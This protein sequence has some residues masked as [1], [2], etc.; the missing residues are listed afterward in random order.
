MV[1][2]IQ[3][4]HQDN[5]DL[6]SLAGELPSELSRLPDEIIDNFESVLV[7]LEKQQGNGNGN[8]SQRP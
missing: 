8:L 3:I 2:V 5:V 4:E 1:H 6:S 7:T